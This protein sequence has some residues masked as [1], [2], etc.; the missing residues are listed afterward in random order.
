[1]E[2]DLFGT[3]AGNVWWSIYEKLPIMVF[4][5]D[6]NGN[7]CMV[8]ERA[9]ADLGYPKEELIGNSVLNVFY[10]GDKEKVL[11]QFQECL[12]AS[13]ETLAKWRFRKIKKTGEM[14]WVGESVS[15]L[16]GS[17]LR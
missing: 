1:M 10:E 4:I 17:C 8:N 14:I 6:S 5:M 13:E 2:K 12:G 11:K 15:N 9:E 16:R 3:Q 7:V